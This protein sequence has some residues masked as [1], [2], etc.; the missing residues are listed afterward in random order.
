V[1]AV[2][3]LDSP[4]PV[5]AGRSRRFTHPVT[6][7]EDAGE[8]TVTA[9]DSVP[10]RRAPLIRLLLRRAGRADQPRCRHETSRQA[11]VRRRAP[12]TARI[13]SCPCPGRRTGVGGAGRP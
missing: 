1:E 2:R 4:A 3:A 11:P 12:A 8:R 9:A 7:R 6:N 5:R 13:R 10:E